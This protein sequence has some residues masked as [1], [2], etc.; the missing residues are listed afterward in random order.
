MPFPAPAPTVSGQEVTVHRFLQ[1]PLEIAR[2]ISELA[3]AEL[4]AEDIFSR[5]D[6]AP[7]GAVIYDEITD[8]YAFADRDPARTTP[9][10]Q[11]PLII[12]SR[13]TPSTANAEEYGG[14]YYVTYDQL[15]R[16]RIRDLDRNQVMLANTLARKW[17]K[18]ALALLDAT[19]DAVGVS[20]QVTGQDFGTSTTDIFANFML[21]QQAAD[22]RQLGIVLDDVTLNPAQFFE[23]VSNEKFQ[24]LWSEETRDA[25]YRD[26][27]TREIRVAGMTIR[28]SHDQPAGE[29]LVT[30]RGL[31]GARHPDP[32][33][34]EAQSNLAYDPETGVWAQSWDDP[35]NTRHWVQAAKSQTMYVDMPYAVYRLEGI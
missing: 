33:P 3:L 2:E 8:N 27:N 12:T 4:F 26:P 31:V 35:E 24:K 29:A 22:A 13:P 23:M 25:F 1:R 19:V 15:K 30:Q 32:P 21:V 18:I 10:G 9:G 11:L 14:K 17:N 34:A 20:A 7:A 28:R 6:P 16:N 5:G